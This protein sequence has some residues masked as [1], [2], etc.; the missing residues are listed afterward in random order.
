MFQSKTH[1]DVRPTRKGGWR[2]PVEGLEGRLLFA[3]GDV[4]T[5]FGAGGVAAATFPGHTSRAGDVAIDAPRGRIL[6]TGTLD[7]FAA[8]S[9]VALAAFKLNGQPDTSFSGDGK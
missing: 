5:A 2:R 3:A 9:H 1:S 8:G 4:D 7:P 6:V